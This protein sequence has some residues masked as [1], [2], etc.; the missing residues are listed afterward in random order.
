MTNMP[1]IYLVCVST[2]WHCLHTLTLPIFQA[3]INSLTCFVSWQPNQVIEKKVLCLA[4]S[5]PLSET[6]FSIPLL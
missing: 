6:T 2:S 1:W 5:L 4:Q 3:L